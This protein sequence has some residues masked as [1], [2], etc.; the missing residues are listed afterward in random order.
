VQFTVDGYDVG[1]PVE[2]SNGQASF[3]TSF[4]DAGRHTI[5]AIYFGDSSY[6]ESAARNLDIQVRQ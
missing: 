3:V 4:G 1:R 6:D 5:S 2:L